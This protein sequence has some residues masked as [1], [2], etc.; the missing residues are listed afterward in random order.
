MQP[1]HGTNTAALAWGPRAPLDPCG[2]CF[3]SVRVYAY[4][5]QAMRSHAAQEATAA[6]HLRQA[7]AEGMQL[8]LPS[9][10]VLY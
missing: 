7:S 9:P 10:Y 4:L 8:L 3:A 5:S 6:Q 1:M 2:E